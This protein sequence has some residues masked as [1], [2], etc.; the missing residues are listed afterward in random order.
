MSYIGSIGQVRF[1]DAP[2]D[3]ETLRTFALSDVSASS[4]A[5]PYLE[6]LRAMSAFDEDTLLIIDGLIE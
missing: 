6:T 5:H 3:L 1:W 4:N 2:L